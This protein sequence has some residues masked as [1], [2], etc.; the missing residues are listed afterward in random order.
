M[1]LLQNAGN[2]TGTVYPMREAGN[3]WMQ[4]MQRTVFAS[5]T[6]GSGTVT[7]QI[8][9]DGL[10]PADGGTDT[11]AA[12]N[13]NSRWFNV[14]TTFTAPGYFTFTDKWRKIR[15]TLAG[16]TGGSVTVEVV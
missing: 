16:A 4:D 8:S 10:N 12:L 15:A 1:F 5:G 14:A 9:P 3:M 7:I 6:F 2:G 13:I 11:N